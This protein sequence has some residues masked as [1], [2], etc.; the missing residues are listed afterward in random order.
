MRAVAPTICH[1]LGCGVPGGSSLPPVQPVISS[2]GRVSRLAFVVIDSLGM[3]QREIHHKG[4]P[5][6]NVFASGGATSLRVEA[7]PYTPVNVAT[8]AT[9]ASFEMHRVRKRGDMLTLATIFTIM[10]RCVMNAYI[11]AE[12]GSTAALLFPSQAPLLTRCLPFVDQD[13][14]NAARE[15]LKSQRPDFLWLYLTGFDRA[16]HT[17]GPGSQKAGEVLTQIDLWLSGL[18]P[19]LKNA[20]YGIIITADHGHH[21]HEGEPGLKGIHDG[22]VEDDLL[23]PLLW[24]C[25]RV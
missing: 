4:T 10:S 8:M 9:G 25:S 6:L 12:K 7:P 2:M 14:C 1:L 19:L 11:L 24:C 20:G 17:Y 16:C 13:I 22:T 15:L 3:T 21:D 23:V 18:A 5:F